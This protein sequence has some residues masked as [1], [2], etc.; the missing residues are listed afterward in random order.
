MTTRPQRLQLQPFAPGYV[1]GVLRRAGDPDSNS[2]LILPAAALDRLTACPAGLIVVDGAPF[3]HAMI[4]LLGLGIPTVLATA[5]QAARLPEGAEALLDG[6]TGLITMPPPPEA[7]PGPP[8]APPPGVAV[9]TADGATV[10]L[11][12]SVA[13]ADGAGRAVR[14]GA[15]GIG[16]VRSEFLLSAS[17][18]VPD[19]AAYHAAL[20]ALCQAA[21]PLPVTVRLLDISPDKRPAWLTPQPGM[22]G[23]LGLQG[24][25]LY[26][27]DPVCRAW[28]AEVAALAE[29]ARDFELAV[30]IP[31]VTHPAEFRHW[32]RKVEQASGSQHLPIGV[33]VETP[34]A[35]L[36]LPAWMELADFV[37]VGCNDLMQC[38]FAADRDQPELAPLLD[39][40]APALYRFLQMLARDAGEAVGRLQLCGLLP[41][42]PKVLP[43]LLGL[44]FRTFSVEPVQI[45]Y[46]ARQV[47]ETRIDRA[48]QLAEALCASHDSAQAR[49]LLA[50]AD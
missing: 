16:L 25:R 26:G 33:M 44:G 1:R 31:F 42:Y 24:V 18:Q 6:A 41:Q 2:L 14:H 30:L 40:Y 9:S 49:S 32:R 43:I 15:G 36:A 19:A 11:R 38:L 3:S 37:A 34:A 20:A 5:A 22:A 35:A 8:A 46:L 17:S 13:D 21:R 10:E 45:P 23:P 50:G 39:P 12:A 4:H 48:T 7:P 47:A 29:L 27:G 28:R